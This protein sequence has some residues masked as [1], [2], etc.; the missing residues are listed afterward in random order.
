[1]VRWGPVGRIGTEQPFERGAKSVRGSEGT[2]AAAPQ[3]PS[4]RPPEQ[5]RQ[6]AADSKVEALGK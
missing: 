1:M 2:S 5:G 6:R 3:F 4:T